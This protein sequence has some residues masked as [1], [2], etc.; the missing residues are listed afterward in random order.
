MRK[1]L[2]VGFMWPYHRGGSGRIPGL[3][4]YLSE[5]GWQ[6]VILTAPL[7]MKPNV[8][9]EI[10]EVPYRLPLEFWMKLLGFNPNESIKRQ[11]SANLDIKSQKSWKYSLVNFILTR[12]R[13]IVYY[14][15]SEKGWEKPAVKAGNELLQKEEI[16]AIITT[17][18]PVITNLIA[19]RLKA[20]HK[21]P[22][23]ADFPHLWSQDHVYPYSS[24]RRWFDR[25]LELKTLSHADALVTVSEPLA[26][27]LRKMHRC[28]P[29]YAITHG[30][31]PEAVNTPPAK[32]TEKFTI[33]YTGSFAPVIREP[34]MLLE[35][36]QSLVTRGMID[37]EKVEARFYGPTESILEGEIEKYGLSGVVKQYGRV[38]H[39][40]SLARQRESQVLF[41]PKPE[42]VSESDVPHPHPMKIFEYLAA[43]RPILATGG[44][45][46]VVDE[47]LEETGAGICAPTVADIEHALEN[48]YREYMEKGEVV[49]RGD[50]SKIN[51]HSQREM[52]RRFVEILDGVTR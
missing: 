2:L 34:T 48:M 10:I 17:S 24:L 28:I 21:I 41:S 23:I 9:C 7:P 20:R 16:S 26:D 5:F 4:K 29:A 25:R 27:I 50:P 38:T 42:G 19:R 8:G 39:E 36:V 22:W 47:L 11:L 6:P 32:L 1:V 14:P 31:E 13:E 3:V 40:I 43:M 44:S 18:P 37:R 52:A 12:A 15:D 30:F 33:T 49:F 35:A 45:K 46:D 51:K